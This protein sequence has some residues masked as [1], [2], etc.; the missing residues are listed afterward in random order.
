MTTFKLPMCRFTYVSINDDNNLPILEFKLNGKK[1]FRKEW[2]E[3]ESAVEFE[4]VCIREL[5]KM[6]KSAY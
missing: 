6:K 5:K 2:K 1:L 4:E 3:G